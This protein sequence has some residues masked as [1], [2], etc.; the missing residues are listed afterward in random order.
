[1][2][3]ADV[4][5]NSASKT[6]AVNYSTKQRNGIMIQEPASGAASTISGDQRASFVQH[7]DSLHPQ[8]PY[9]ED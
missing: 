6:V 3:P 4:T 7:R 5:Y 1:M 9:T 8:A 2:L